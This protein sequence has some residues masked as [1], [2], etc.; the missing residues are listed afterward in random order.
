MLVRASTRGVL[1]LLSPPCDGNKSAG[2]HHRACDIAR[3]GASFV[4]V[5][6]LGSG[7]ARD[8]QPAAGR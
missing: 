8:E 3:R 1:R 5:L 7:R 6:G 2:L 4:A